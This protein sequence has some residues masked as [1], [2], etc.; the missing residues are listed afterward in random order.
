MADTS[1]TWWDANAQ[2]S[3]QSVHWLASYGISNIFQHGGRSPFWILKFLIFDHVIVAVVLIYCC[4]PNFIKIGSRVRLPGAHNCWMFN[5]P[6]LGN[7][8]CHGN[9][10]TADT[11]RRERD[12]MRPPKFY[13]NRSIDWRVV[14]FSTFCNMAAVR[15]LELEF[16]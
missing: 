6:L 5:A 10:I 1:G 15:Y 7:G 14:A 8:S 3:S 12:G 16:C 11:S 9:R 2:A 13:P 4:V